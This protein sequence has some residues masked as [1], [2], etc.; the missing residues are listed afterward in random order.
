MDV[1]NRYQRQMAFAPFGE[2]GQKKLN[3]SQVVIIGCGALGTVAANN[4]ARSGVGRLKIVDRD[5]VETE[6]LERQILFDE[7]DARE[8]TPK[9]IAAVNR[10]KKVNSTIK[11]EAEVEDV[12]QKNIE[13]IIKGFDLVLDDTDNMETRFIINDACIKNQTTWIYAGVIGATGMVMSIV[14]NKTACLKCLIEELPPPGTLPTCYQEGVLNTITSAIASI[15]TTEAIK[16]LLGRNSGG[17]LIKFDI[18]NGAFDKFKVNRRPDCTACV[19][20][21]FEFLQQ[22]NIP[23]CK[24]ICGRNQVHINPRREVDIDLNALSDRL[25]HLGSVS[26]NEFLLNFS[27][28]GYDIMIFKSGRA[29]IKGTTDESIARTI[30]SRYV[31][32]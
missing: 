16:T 17:R 19:R 10:L 25:K 15:Q 22:E 7:E 21:T 6:N 31:G 28:G 8:H 14:P 24:V 9:A 12:N 3:A 1:K 30:Y 26:G 4:L 18:W 11:L 2:E 29:M 5:V 13:R 23:W 32:I 20:H 27:D